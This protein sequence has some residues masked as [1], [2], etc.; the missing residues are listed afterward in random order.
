MTNRYQVSGTQGEFQSGSDQQVL[1]NKLGI[2]SPDD[3]NE[4]ELG[5]LTQLYEEVLVNALPERQLTV[6]DI[7]TWHHR[8][9]GNVYAWAGQE[10]TVNLSKGDFMFAAAPQ[11][12]RLL[13]EFE[14]TCLVKWTPCHDMTTDTLAQAMAV[15]HVELILIHPFREGNGRLAR[16]LV[17]VMAVQSGR[18][19]LDYSAW[20]AHKA[21]YFAAIQQGMAGNY[22]PMTYWVTQA[23][24]GDGQDLK[25]PV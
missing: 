15:T 25:L 19:P 24:S 14:R 23:L 22:S 9:L 1:A 6:A 16:L 2:T 18:E 4:L 11:I 21:E 20:E 5:L 12:A 10:R 8:W 17:D 13:A 3:M 7:K